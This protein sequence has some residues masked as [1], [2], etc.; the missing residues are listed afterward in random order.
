M[1]K[2]ICLLIFSYLIGSIPNAFW[3]G[4]VFK[5]IDIRQQGSGNVGATNA[6]RVLGYKYGFMTL[7]LDVLKGAIPTYIGYKMGA[8][9]GI[10]A[11][12]C[13]IIRH[14][15]SI[16]LKFKGGKA[17]ATTVG[18]FL[19]ISPYS[20]LALLV[21]FFAIV[22]LTGYVSIASMVSA[23]CLAVAVYLFKGTTPEIIFSII[24]GLFV[25]YKHKSNI[26]NLINKK[27]AKFFD[28]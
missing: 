14:S 3:I 1:I 11:A 8:N 22:F 17:V 24:I 18:I 5:N 13:A 12:I 19:I 25:I 27:E 23:L 20:I 6:A 2:V 7:V 28:K 4:K 10:Y 21:V 16:F 26:K 9:L 15:Y